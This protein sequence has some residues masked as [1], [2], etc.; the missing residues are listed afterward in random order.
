MLSL[1]HRQI[2]TNGNSLSTSHLSPRYRQTENRKR[3]LLRG[4]GLTQLSNGYN[5]RLTAPSL[6]AF[7]SGRGRRS[8]VSGLVV[9][10][11]HVH[12]WVSETEREREREREEQ[13]S[14]PNRKSKHWYHDVMWIWMFLCKWR[15]RKQISLHRGIKL[16]CIVLYCISPTR[17]TNVK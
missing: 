5:C 1:T 11:L 14:S 2:R 4:P 15:A 8:A 7:Y 12:V 10:L 13:T 6:K 9:C 17:W 16:Y 3:F